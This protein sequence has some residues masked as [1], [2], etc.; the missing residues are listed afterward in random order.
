MRWRQVNTG[1]AVPNHYNTCFASIRPRR[2]EQQMVLIVCLAN[3]LTS[4]VWTDSK[5]KDI[6]ILLW[7][8][9]PV[10]TIC[11]PDGTAHDQISPTFLRGI[12]IL[13][14][15]K[16][17][18]WEWPGNEATVFAYCKRSNVGGGNGLG[19]SYALVDAIR[20]CPATETW[21]MNHRLLGVWFSQ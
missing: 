1:G 16:C 5:T 2:C 21:A 17:W 13:Q 18:L 20:V 10:S 11:L 19:M 8:P 12:C 15:I 9:P 7:A 3:V 14:A 6:D 4:S